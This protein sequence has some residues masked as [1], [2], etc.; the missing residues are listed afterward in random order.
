[1]G[2]ALLATA[3]LAAG[4]A[5]YGAVDLRFT[6]GYDDSLDAFGIHGVGGIPGALLTGLSATT[7]VNPAGATGLFYGHPRQLL[8]QLV[9][10]LIVAG[11]VMSARVVMLKITRAV[12][13][14]RLEGAR[15]IDG[16]DLSAHGESGCH[17]DEIP[18]GSGAPAHGSRLASS[19]T[20]QVLK[21]A[22]QQAETE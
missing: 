10:V 13:G 14:L 7:A 11:F 3:A 4:G 1:M 8:I 21:R 22:M 20:L 16:M 15:E 2:A 17:L 12:T 18:M 9:S 19:S 6:P 5:C